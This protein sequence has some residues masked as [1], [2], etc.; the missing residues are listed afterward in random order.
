VGGKL[1]SIYGEILHLQPLKMNQTKLINL[2]IFG[3]YNKASIGDSAILQGIIDQFKLN[4]NSLTV[5]A[6][7]PVDIKATVDFYNIREKILACKPILYKKKTEQ[8]QSMQQNQF[9]DNLRK[10]IKKNNTL[11]RSIYS[12]YKSK[13]LLTLA[14]DFIIYYSNKK[15]WKKITREIE[16]LDLLIIGGGNLIMDLYP[17]WPIYPLIYALL[18]K[19]AKIPIML[20]AIGAGPINSFKARI[21]F[22]IIGHLADVVTTRDV[23]ST[24]EV[25]TLGIRSPKIITSAD[26]DI[27]INLNKYNFKI[28]QKREKIGITVVPY[29]DKRYWPNGDGMIYKEY[30]RKMALLVDEIVMQL[31]QEVLFFATNFPNDLLVSYDIYKK[32]FRKEKIFIVENRLTIGEILSTILQCQIILGT[33]LH[34]LIL[35]YT[36]TTPFLAFGYQPKVR[37]FCE[38]YWSNDFF[39]PLDK[40]LSFSIRS[41]VNKLTILLN[42]RDEYRNKME[43]TLPLIKKRANVSKE[44]ALNIIRKKRN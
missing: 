34:S 33:R 19:K 36:T 2:G 1:N 35:S 6:F 3:S 41:T 37:S 13:S 12:F 9:I 28:G 38:E 26:N 16:K 30:V 29:Y 44:I 24:K 23:N 42:N 5:F 4:L 43:K 11:S 15:F 10:L 7:D 27:Y 22:K 32:S 31:N 25:R 20:Y 8:I 39:V 21:Y 14:I 40:K 17:N 18:A